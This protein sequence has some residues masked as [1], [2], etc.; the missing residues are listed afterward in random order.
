MGAEAVAESA[1]QAHEEGSDGETR[2]ASASADAQTAT[3]AAEEPAAT[4]ESEAEGSV[5]EVTL[6]VGN[7]ACPYHA[8]W[9]YS[10]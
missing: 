9:S 7:C 2:P 5:K 6:E 1:N 8:L 3:T 10:F 4:G